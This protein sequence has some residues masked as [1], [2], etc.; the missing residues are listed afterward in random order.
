M[1]IDTTVDRN[2]EDTVSEEFLVRELDDL[3][4]LKTERKGRTGILASVFTYTNC[5]GS[6]SGGCCSFGRDCGPCRYQ[7]P[8]PAGVRQNP[9]EV[10]QK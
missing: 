9:A 10:Q 8:R 3:Y 5:G 6:C 7:P 4:D 1:A 2:A